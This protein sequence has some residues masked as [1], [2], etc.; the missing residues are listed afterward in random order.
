MHKFLVTFLG[1]T[2]WLTILFVP[3]SLQQNRRALDSAERVLKNREREIA[4]MLILD[5]KL[6]SLSTTRC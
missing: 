2:A 6:G 4:L 5:V 1:L 3:L